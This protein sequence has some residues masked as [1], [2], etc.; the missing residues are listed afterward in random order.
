VVSLRGRLTDFRG[1]KT[2]IENIE[3]G[4]YQVIVVDAYYRMIPSGTSENDN[5]AVAGI[6]N[7]IDQYAAMTDAAWLLIHHATKGSQS[8]KAVTDVGAGAGSQSRAADCHL[9]LRPHEEDGCIVLEAAVRSFKPVEP[10]V[11]QW[12]FPLWTPREDMNPAELKGRKTRTEERQSEKDYEG[13]MKIV[14]VHPH[15]ARS[16]E[17]R[18]HRCHDAL[19]VSRQDHCDRKQ[20]CTQRFEIHERNGN[21]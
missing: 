19:V 14:E 11:L 1:L 12:E 4:K 16:G 13:S 8:D 5:S 10:L 20:I 18:R 9:I 21:Q 17:R 3:T 2:I 6:Y 7:L 15:W